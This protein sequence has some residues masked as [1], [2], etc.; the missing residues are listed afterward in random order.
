MSLKMS[1]TCIVCAWVT[2]MDMWIGILIVYGVDQRIFK[3]Y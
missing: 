3:E 2:L 1:E